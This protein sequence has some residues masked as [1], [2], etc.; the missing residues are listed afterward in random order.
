MTAF[1]A[2]GCPAVRGAIAPRHARDALPARRANRRRRRSGAVGSRRA[3]DAFATRW[4]TTRLGGGTIRVRHTFDALLRRRIAGPAI[5]AVTLLIARAA[6]ALTGGSVAGEPVGARASSA[7]WMAA[8][9]TRPTRR[10]RAAAIRVRATSLAAP[11][12]AELSRPGRAVCVRGTFGAERARARRRR[13][14][15][16][17]RGRVRVHEERFG[18][19][20]PPTRGHERDDEPDAEQWQKQARCDHETSHA[21]IEVEVPRPRRQQAERVKAS[22]VLKA[23]TKMRLPACSRWKEG[24]FLEMSL[25]SVFREPDE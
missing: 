23:R 19:R 11:E 7:A 4:M 20:R 6:N 9:I 13:R 16:A 1:T 25:A 8:V 10:R 12:N 5:A 2:E 22:R 17:V 24:T 15:G 3:R 18:A 21:T 14:G